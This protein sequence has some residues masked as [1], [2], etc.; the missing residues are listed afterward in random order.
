MCSF[1]DSIFSDCYTFTLQTNIDDAKVTL[2]TLQD[3][4]KPD[5]TRVLDTFDLTMGTSPLGRVAPRYWLVK[6]KSVKIFGGDKVEAIVIDDDIVKD[7][8]GGDVNTFK[9]VSINPGSY[10]VVYNK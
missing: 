2:T 9:V 6:P 8:I 5:S 7:R 10:T 3:F 4:L 1:I